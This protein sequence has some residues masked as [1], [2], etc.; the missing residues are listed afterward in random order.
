MGALLRISHSGMGHEAFILFVTR[1]VCWA[2][3]EQEGVH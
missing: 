1:I 3:I 2:W